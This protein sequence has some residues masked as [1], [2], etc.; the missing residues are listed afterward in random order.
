MPTIQED[1]NVQNQQKTARQNRSINN[2]IDI[3]NKKV[4]SLYKDI[5]VTRTDN[6][7]NLDDI[8]DSIDNTIDKLQGVSNNASGMA[9]L[10]RRLDNKG[11]TNV[12]K[13]MGSVSDLFDDDNLIGNIVMND[14][15]H[16]FIKAQN[17]NYDLICRWLPRLQDALEVKRDAVLS[18][19][20][21]SKEFLIPKCPSVAKDEIVTFDANVDKLEKEYDMSEFLDDTYM[22]VSK[23]GEDF[24]YVVPYPV[25]FERMF[26][27]SRKRRYSGSAGL[28]PSMMFEGY[29]EEKVVPDQFTATSEFISYADAIVGETGV[30]A[31][32]AL[33][34]IPKEL[35]GVN[36]Y[37]NMSN[38]I[39]NSVSEYAIFEEVADVDKFDS[40]KSIYEA[41]SGLTSVFNND[42]AKKNKQPINVGLNNDGLILSKNID[43]RF[44][45]KIDQDM[46]GTVL[47]RIPRENILPIYIGKRCIGYYYFEFAEDPSACGFCG[48]HHAFTGGGTLTSNKYPYQ[49]SEDQQE[50][51]LRYIAAQLSSRID[52]KFINANKDLKEEIYG[53]LRYNE[54]FDISRTNNI[55]VTFLPADDVVHCYFKL[56]EHTHR[57]I[58][59]LERALIPA[60]LYILLYLTDIIGKITR[61]NDK[62]VYYV[63]QNV[64]KNVARTMMNVV[65]QIKKGNMGVRQIESMNNIL[66][67]VGK[68]NDYIIPVGPSGDPP[69]QFDIM[70]GQDVQTPTELMEKMEEAAINTIMPFELLN[71]TYQQD[72][73][74]RY[75]MSNIRYMRTVF[76]RQRKVEKFFSKIYTPTYNYEFGTNYQCIEIMLPPPV[77]MIVQNN[78]QMIDNFSQMADKIADIEL[79]AEQDDEIKPEFKKRYIRANLGEYLDYSQIDNIISLAKVAVEA[80]KT[81]AVEETNPEDLMDD[82]L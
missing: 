52:I 11:H 23:Y 32:D 57:G 12:D 29:V 33:K 17:Y 77:A 43:D 54:K 73:A 18:S 66:N 8:I 55:G 39:Q 44:N 30:L 16:R 64:E 76:T 69:I 72:F 78:S 58:S 80:A 14:D 41:N 82:S 51:A 22:N 36:L 4:N 74:T 31:E 63:K 56:D 25:A 40:L 49:M 70:Q 27:R 20:N 67:I 24:I 50:L 26:N 34:G 6:M 65:A 60:M 81:P 71:A 48:G 35:G 38:T 37:F 28:S 68:Y 46:L 10:L 2:K 15:V 13:L 45:G 79:T 47:E 42:I 75:T 3:L 53:I 19:D 62:R 59:D 5:Y 1:S 9:E 21:F 7:R 61:S